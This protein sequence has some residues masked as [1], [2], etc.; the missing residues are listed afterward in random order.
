LSRA[1]FLIAIRTKKNKYHY[2]IKEKHPSQ[3]RYGQI[4]KQSINSVT[5]KDVARL[6]G[7]SVAVVSYVV[8]NGPRQVSPEMRQK[9]LDAIDALGYHP[10]KYAQNL[11]V[12]GHQTQRQIGVLVGG[13]TEML[14]RPYYGA[15]LSGIYDE[16][17]RKGLRVRFTHFIDE[18]HDPVLFNEHF[19]SDEIGAL[20]LL[21]PHLAI[22]NEANAG[23]LKKVI[24][25]IDRV[26]CLEKQ[27][28]DL[29]TVMFDREAAARTAVEHLIKI[30]H[31]K[32]GFMGRP[33]ERLT[34]Y[35]LTM[36]NAGLE[37]DD[38]L[39]VFSGEQNSFTEGFEGAKIYLERQNMPT[40]LFAA[41]DEVAV[42][43]MGLF[44]D[45]HIQIP[46][47][48]AYHQC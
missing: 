14:K 36:R 37:I 24:T 20:I 38:D 16:A 42:G 12:N 1:I 25:R 22:E 21:S 3:F 35:Q 26:V 8:N 48:M 5:Q 9:V 32:I 29:P 28:F 23:I 6:A 27:V 11:K 45:H 13:S 31:R 19:N 30:G 7:V 10:N 4:M 33:D 18:L 34:G 44:S 47:D 40:A 2:N 17:Y 41:N 43:A 39:I 46:D 15:I